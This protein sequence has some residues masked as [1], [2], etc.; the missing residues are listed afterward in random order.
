MTE[1]TL[2]NI[3]EQ[4][5]TFTIK[6]ISFRFRFYVYRDLMYVDIRKIGEYIVRAKRVLANKWLIPEYH[7]EGIGNIRFETYE[8]D[9]ED[10]VWYEDFNTKFRLV[11]YTAAEIDELKRQEEEK[12]KDGN[13]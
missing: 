9:S 2:N 13:P 12:S 4:E 3:P 1:R 5:R 6:Q 8:A 10:Y 7:G 11:S